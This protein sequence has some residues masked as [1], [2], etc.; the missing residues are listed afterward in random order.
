MSK[1]I[2][3]FLIGVGIDGRRDDT[4]VEEGLIVFS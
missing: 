2:T 3:E 4:G 1:Y